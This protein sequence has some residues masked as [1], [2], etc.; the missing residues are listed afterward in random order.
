MLILTILDKLNL[1]PFAPYH[2]KAFGESVMFTSS[3][4]YEITNYF[5]KKKIM[6]KFYTMLIKITNLFKTMM[7]VYQLIK[8]I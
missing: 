3:K 7:K 5:P 4:A 6:L 8:K 1:S 2:Y